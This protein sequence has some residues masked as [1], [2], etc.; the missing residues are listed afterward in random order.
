VQ[1]EAGNKEEEQEMKKRTY[2]DISLTPLDWAR[3]PGVV[4][5]RQRKSA[6]TMKCLAL[7]R[8]LDREQVK[9]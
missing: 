7:L 6:D 1:D 2:K 3:Q 5:R 9:K 8:R 4:V